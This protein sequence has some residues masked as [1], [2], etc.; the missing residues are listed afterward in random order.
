MPPGGTKGSRDEGLCGLLQYNALLPAVKGEW[1]L[2]DIDVK[3]L[4]A[5]RAAPIERASRRR[6]G[7]D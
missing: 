3:P 5:A 1:R 4:E 6:Y 7:P 2:C